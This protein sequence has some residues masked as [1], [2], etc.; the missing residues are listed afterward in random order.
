MIAGHNDF[1]THKFQASHSLSA[2]TPVISSRNCTN[3]S[4]L[5][6]VYHCPF[7][8]GLRFFYNK[9]KFRHGP[10][11]Q[12]SQPS[13]WLPSVNTNSKDWY[14]YSG[15]MR[16]QHVIMKERRCNNGVSGWST[17]CTPCEQC[18]DIQIC[19]GIYAFRLR[20]LPLN[21]PMPL[22]Y[23]ERR[24]RYPEERCHDICIVNSVDPLN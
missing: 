10:H 19:R 13:Y 20:N 15:I 8:V 5:S 3:F 21:F 18:L 22:T 17:V 7:N 14:C 16:M 1:F 12:F 11:Q 24:M 23:L 6:V 9:G 2:D 4:D